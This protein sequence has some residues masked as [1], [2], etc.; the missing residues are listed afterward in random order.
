M[1][2]QHL[3]SLP[4]RATWV[5]TD[6]SATGAVT[7]GGAGALII[8]P[9]DDR[10]ELRLPVGA[11]CSSFRAEMTALRAALDH[12]LDHPGDT[13]DPVVCFTASTSALAA[14]REGPAVQDSQQGAEVWRRLLAVSPRDDPS[15]FSGSPRTVGSPGTTQPTSWR[16]RRRPWHR[17]R[18]RSTPPPYA[19]QRP[20]RPG[21]VRPETDRATRSEPGP[22]WAG[23]GS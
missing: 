12:L 18:L 9:N 21:S 4:Q 17:V 13:E 19:E 15:T 5:W 7:D 10:H 20:A 22:Q 6:G 8:S 16:G 23:T 14:L 11:L 3:A 2:L 1:A